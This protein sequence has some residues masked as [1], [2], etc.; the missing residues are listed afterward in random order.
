MRIVLGVAVAVAAAFTIACDGSPVMPSAL[1]SAPAPAITTP[2][3][4][5][6]FRLTADGADKAFIEWAERLHQSEVE[7][8]NLAQTNGDHLAVKLFAGQMMQEHGLALDRL[9]IAA[10]GLYSSSIVLDATQ[11]SQRT[12]L[13]STTGSAADHLYVPMMVT[14]HEEALAR[15]QREETGASTAAMREYAASMVPNM[16]SHLQM[17]QDLATKVR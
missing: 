17:A 10:A 13:S 12:S 4:G 9:R 2:S 8:G 15:F 11:Q 5:G 7:F 6:T 1:P 3:S 14:I 16:R